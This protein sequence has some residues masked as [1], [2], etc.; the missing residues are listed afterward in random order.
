MNKQ[1]DYPAFLLSTHSVCTAVHSSC[2]TRSP[3]SPQVTN[4]TTTTR[5]HLSQP[6]EHILSAVLSLPKAR[7]EPADNTRKENRDLK[8]LIRRVYEAANGRQVETPIG[9]VPIAPPVAAHLK[10][11]PFNVETQLEFFVEVMS[12]LIA[13]PSDTSDATTDAMAALK[14]RQFPIDSESGATQ[15]QPERISEFVPL[16]LQQH[17]SRYMP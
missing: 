15:N 5:I 1:Y 3:F 8:Q 6:F 13:S 10:E 4:F 2:H 14:E 16:S 12:R 7:G 17:F 11:A 9:P